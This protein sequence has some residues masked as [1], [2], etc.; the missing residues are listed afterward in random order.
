MK[1]GMANLEEAHFKVNG[2]FYALQGRPYLVGR[3]PLALGLILNAIL[4]SKTAGS[5][6]ADPNRKSKLKNRK[7]Q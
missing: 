5:P 3:A 4:L 2:Q 1:L 7:S 6:N